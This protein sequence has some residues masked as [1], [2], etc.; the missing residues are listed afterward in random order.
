MATMT[1]IFRAV[2]ASVYAVISTGVLGVCVASTNPQVVQAAMGRSEPL[3]DAKI[4][5]IEET[6][7]MV[8]H[9]GKGA[10][11]QQISKR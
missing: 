8:A 7:W 5:E 1:R 4:T 10:G 9:T 6:F 3:P 2:P 11:P